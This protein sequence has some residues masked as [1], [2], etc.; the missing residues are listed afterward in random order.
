MAT[1]VSHVM[2]SVLERGIGLPAVV[3]VTICIGI[4]ALVA[5]VSTGYSQ[6]GGDA[7]TISLL[8]EFGSAGIFRQ[9]V[10]PGCVT[11]FEVA[12]ICAMRSLIR[13]WDVKWVVMTSLVVVLVTQVVWTTQFMTGSYGFNDTTQIDA[14]ARALNEGDMSKFVGVDEWVGPVRWDVPSYL[15]RVPYQAGM[16]WLFAGVY[17]VFG[18]GNYDAIQWLN[19]VANLMSAM[20][21]IGIVAETTRGENGTTDGMSVKLSALA[22]A[23]FFPFLMSAPFVY[24]NSIAFAFVVGACYL[25]SWAWARRTW[26]T[27]GIGLVGTALLMSLGIMMKQTFLLVSIVVILCWVLYALKEGKPLVLVPVAL[28][29]YAFMHACDL[30]IWCLEQATGIRLGDGQPL[31]ANITLGLTWSE[32][33]NAPGWYSGVAFECYNQTDGSIAAQTTWC[34]DYIRDRLREMMADPRYAFYFFRYKVTSEW[35][36]PSW[37]SCWFSAIGL[38]DK[39]PNDL[40]TQSAISTFA[41][42]KWMLAILDGMQT[43]LY[44]LAAVGFASEVKRVRNGTCPLGYLMVV[45]VVLI[46]LVVYLFW[47]AQAMYTLPFAFMMLPMVAK[48]CLALYDAIDGRKKG[49]APSGADAQAT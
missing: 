24:S 47:E 49:R 1:R 14:Y 20:F 7:G 22:V 9:L 19:V 26:K 35:L 33:N 37:Q 43:V 16:V 4:L 25:S 45:G 23:S 36:D 8:S 18:N 12:V 28:M 6:I 39:V 2:A 11:L 30:P 32:G 38:G 3:M 42:N 29:A 17:R 15:I 48:G 27:D 10:V 40:I 21:L 41:A 34:I 46:G 31:F 44:G 13:R 5:V